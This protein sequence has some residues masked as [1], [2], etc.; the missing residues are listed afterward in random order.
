MLRWWKVS[1]IF[2]YTCNR[3]L[4]VTLYFG[5]SVH[6]EPFKKIYMFFFDYWTVFSTLIQ[7]IH[8][9]AP[10]S[11]WFASIFPLFP[12]KRLILRLTHYT[13]GKIKTV[14]CHPS[15]C[16]TPQRPARRFSRIA[17]P[18]KIFRCCYRLFVCCCFFRGN[19]S[20]HF[21]EHFVC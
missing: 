8:E 7:F 18:P 3:I 6:N 11:L 4:R 20:M 10:R 16:P 5:K 15:L 9:L 17:L 1:R 13:T 21:K 19:Y 2:R 12:Q 14:K